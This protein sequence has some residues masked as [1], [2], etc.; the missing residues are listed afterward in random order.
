MAENDIDHLGEIIV[1]HIDRVGGA[2][3]FGDAGEVPEIGIQDRHFLRFAA[4]AAFALG[5]QL[6]GHLLAHI[7]GHGGFK[8]FF[9][10]DVLD[11]DHRAD[12]LALR[13]DQRDDGQIHG[14]LLAVRLDQIFV[15]GGVG[16]AGGL[17]LGD[18]LGDPGVGVLEQVI[19]GQPQQRVARRNLQY[20]LGGIVDGDHAPLVVEG[21]QSVGGALE[22][23]VVV[24]FDGQHLVEQL[25]V[26]QRHGDLRGE[27]TEAR[28]VPFLE[29]TPFLLRT[30]VTP[31]CSPALLVI[32]MQRM[33]SVL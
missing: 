29:Q 28:L 4:Q 20:G 33:L 24:V 17:D 21:D 13:V 27:G 14:N 9:I 19:G 31:I 22:D 23:T 12:D 11:D 10:G 30:W 26:V 8:P 32:G 3:T 25:R 2:E 6:I 5:Q 18:G 7:A 16:I 15:D 1:Q